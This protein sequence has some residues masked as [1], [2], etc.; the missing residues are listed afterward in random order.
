MMY[1]FPNVCSVKDIKKNS[2]IPWHLGILLKYAFSMSPES[3]NMENNSNLHI[4]AEFLGTGRFCSNFL[5]SPI[6]GVE[7]WK[8]TKDLPRF[9]ISNKIQ[10]FWKQLWQNGGH[11]S[12]FGISNKMLFLFQI[13]RP[14]KQL[15]FSVVFRF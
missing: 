8:N 13:F 14:S 2:R 12:H 9:A 6:S 15:H 5:F 1:C 11:N 3:Q 10:F 7:V 4:W